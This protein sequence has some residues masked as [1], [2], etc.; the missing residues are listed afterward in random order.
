MKRKVYR[1]AIQSI[2][3]ILLLAVY[4]MN[5]HKFLIRNN[6]IDAEILVV[7]GW[8]PDYALD[9]AINEFR[10]NKYK[11]LITTG[12]YVS[13]FNSIE[14]NTTEAQAAR[15]A[16]LQKGIGRDSIFAVSA[17]YT[18]ADRSYIS[19]KA[20]RLWMLNKNVKYKSFNLFTYGPHS[21]RSLASFEKAFGKDYT[22]GVITVTDN[23][24][25]YNNWF[26]SFSG[27]RSI[28]EETFAWIYVRLFFYPRFGIK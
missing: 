4:I 27:I 17:K 21:R 9:K 22:I 8:I 11:Y 15:R 14:S 20:L 16:L 26:K 24:N 23:S 5:V 19:A 2:L 1:V 7:E 10:N 3:F 25:S 13:D 28:V 12:V 18:F 6:P